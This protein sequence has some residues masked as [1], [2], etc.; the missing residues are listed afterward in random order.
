MPTAKADGRTMECT[1]ER[2]FRSIEAE[3]ASCITHRGQRGRMDTVSD[4]DLTI[5]SVLNEELREWLVAELRYPVLG[6]NSGNGPPSQSV[7]WFELDPGDPN[8]VLMNTKVQRLKYRQ[9]QDDPRVSLLFED[10]ESW[11]AMRGTVELDATVGPA[12]DHIKALARRYGSDPARFDGQL[13]V[14]IRMRVEKV[15]RHD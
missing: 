7:M 8:V 9:L 12:L 10:G 5:Q 3:I 2:G 14:I 6:V 15:I 4:P 13:R 1:A 11:L